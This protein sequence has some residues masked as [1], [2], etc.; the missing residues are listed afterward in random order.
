MAVISELETLLKVS[1][2]TSGA[3]ADNTQYTETPERTVQLPDQHTYYIN[4]P[5]HP[6]SGQVYVSSQ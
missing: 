2:C 5:I 4:I 6:L 3:M 1:A